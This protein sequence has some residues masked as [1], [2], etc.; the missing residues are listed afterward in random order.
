MMDGFVK[1]IILI[2]EMRIDMYILWREFRDGILLRMG[3][4]NDGK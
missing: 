4:I 3:V 1:L 2:E